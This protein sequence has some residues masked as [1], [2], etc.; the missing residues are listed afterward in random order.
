MAFALHLDEHLQRPPE[1]SGNKKTGGGSLIGEVGHACSELRGALL[2]PSL[3]S[4]MPG[5][6]CGRNKGHRHRWDIALAERRGYIGVYGI[7]LYHHQPSPYHQDM[8]IGGPG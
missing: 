2:I 7:R 5:G 8:S 6:Y 1:R 3:N 4:T